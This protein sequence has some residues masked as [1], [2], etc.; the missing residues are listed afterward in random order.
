GACHDSWTAPFLDRAVRFRGA[1]GVANDGGGGA[2]VVVVVVVE[3]GVVVVVV[4]GVVVVGVVA[5]T[6]ALAS[7]SFG[8]PVPGSVTSFGVAWS[9]IAAAT[10]SGVAFGWSERYNAATPVTCGVAIDVPLSVLVEVSLLAHADWIDTPG[11]KT[12]THGPK[13]ENDARASL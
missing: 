5:S 3:A 9:T 2:V 4:V 13:F 1:L 12:S 8:E 6:N 10:S 11:A 7:S